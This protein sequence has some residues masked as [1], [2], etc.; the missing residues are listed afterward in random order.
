MMMMTET[1]DTARTDAAI[2]REIRPA[3]L[4]IGG[5]LL[6]IWWLEYRAA[7]TPVQPAFLAF[8]AV[9]VVHLTLYVLSTRVPDARRWLYLIAQGALVTLLLLLVSTP[10]VGLSLA[11][12]MLAETLG[13]LG[14]TRTASLWSVGL[15]LVYLSVSFVR[16]PTGEFWSLLGAFLPTAVFIVVAM[17]LI[18]RQ[19]AARAETQAL[20]D[21]LERANRQLAAYAEQ[22]QQLTR[23][24]E[25]RRIARDLHDTLAQGLA[26]TVLQLEAAQLYVS[27]GQHARAGEI[28]SG[29]L[30]LTR[31]TL[32]DA[33]A[34]I[35]DLRRQEGNKPD[36]IETI[37]RAI[38]VF[39]AR[40]G[41]ECEL[42]VAP[43]V[44]EQALNSALL[45]DVDRVVQE[46]LTNAGRHA[47][48]TSVSVLL[49]QDSGHLR[50]RVCD[51]G[52]GFDPGMPRPTGHYGL[53]GM[54]ERAEWI[55]ARLS[56][57][58]AAGHGTS[59]TLM[60]PEDAD[61]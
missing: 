4:F 5:F 42:I 27:Q 16:M 43:G 33:R 54:R 60:L 19:V 34:A 29:A 45:A 3:Y 55:G 21:E 40:Y 38:E 15:A 32:H 47:E 20:A 41:V 2:I 50:V 36:L 8:S 57:D 31:D 44:A 35:D 7:A 39:Q 10:A 51:D 17:V 14:N 37:E 6:L 23:L 49:D 58:S 13:V 11:V 46:A 28:I 30:A 26:G 52:R 56:V 22:V 18:N 9:L 48:A 24:A 59:I 25:R 1:P 53:L 61:A 12:T